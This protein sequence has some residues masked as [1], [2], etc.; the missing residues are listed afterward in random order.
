MFSTWS[1]IL[2]QIYKVLETEEWISSTFVYYDFAYLFIHINYL[3]LSLE[4]STQD[5][6]PFFTLFFCF[7][8]VVFVNYQSHVRYLFNIWVLIPDSIR[9]NK[10][11]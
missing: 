10:S 7:D 11:C 4:F 3:I 6:T 1:E 8:C 2:K 5:S 9:F